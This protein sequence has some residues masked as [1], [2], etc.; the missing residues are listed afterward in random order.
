MMFMHALTACVR[1]CMHAHVQ[2]SK[3]AVP[4]RPAWCEYSQM[5][6]L[7][8]ASHSIT[9]PLEQP[10]TSSF[11]SWDRD[12]QERV[13]ANLRGGMQ[14]VHAV[15]LWALLAQQVDGLASA[16]A[17]SG[18]AMPGPVLLRLPLRLLR[19]PLYR[20]PNPHIPQQRT[21]G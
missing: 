19:L 11:E 17:L 9:R 10:A 7:S 4:Y 18:H 5:F 2:A 16:S 12:T 13:S 15:G 8:S 21:C 14:G 20:H 3:Q 1:K 6:S